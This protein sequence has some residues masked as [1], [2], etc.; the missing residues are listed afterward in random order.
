MCESSVLL[1][2]KLSREALPFGRKPWVLAGKSVLSEVKASSLRQPF[3]EINLIISDL[4][5]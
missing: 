5:I 2:H 4:L 3:L 1:D